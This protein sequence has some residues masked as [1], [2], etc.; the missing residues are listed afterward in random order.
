MA[1]SKP[2]MPSYT[3]IF[4]NVRLV[5]NLLAAG[6]L[7]WHTELPVGAPNL[8]FILHLSCL[9]HYT[10][11]VPLLA[12]RILKK[13]NID[14]PILGGPE[15]C[16]G[17]LHAH[18]GDNDL[19]EETARIGIASFRKARPTTVLSLCPDCDETFSQFMPQKKPFFHSN[20]S[21]IFAE[22]IEELRPLMRPVNRRVVIH[23]HHSNEQRIRDAKNIETVLRAIPGLVIVESEKHEGE[24]PHC[25]I[26]APMP[27]VK[28]RAMFDEAV[29]LNADSLIVPY[30][31]C[32][33]QHLKL[34]LNWKVSVKHYLTILG[35]ALGIEE[36]EE[37]KRLRMLDN[38]DKA[39]EA[40]RPRFEPLGY[41]S[42]QVRPLVAWSIYC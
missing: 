5:G 17:A 23:S 32:Y 36:D 12:Q 1:A 39:V 19:C 25:Q 18:L 22:R 21:E 3:G 35:E 20:I 40:L 16:C 8:P 10:P 7:D 13:I 4:D 31:S 33:R 27:P 2:N 34:E 26:L 24:G 37:Y 38:V 28:Q 42:E 29:A 9:V 6:K 30:H 11:H 15:N 14:C 41:T